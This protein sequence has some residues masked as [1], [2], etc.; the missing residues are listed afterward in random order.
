MPVLGGEVGASERGSARGYVCSGMPPVFLPFSIL[1]IHRDSL[2]LL[3]LLLQVH[4]NNQHSPFNAL[5]AKDI[6]KEDDQTEICCDSFLIH[7]D[8]ELIR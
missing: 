4:S 1:I 7:R 3:I 8:L 2:L 6:N 5:A